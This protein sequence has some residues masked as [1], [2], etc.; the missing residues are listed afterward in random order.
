MMA[1]DEQNVLISS[2]KGAG[3]KRRFQKALLCKPLALVNRHSRF[4][5]RKGNTEFELLRVS[6]VFKFSCCLLSWKSV[7]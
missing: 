2:V 3:V 5:F 6:C 1:S 4:S 7:S